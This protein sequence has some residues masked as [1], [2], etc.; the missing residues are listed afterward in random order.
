MARRSSTVEAPAPVPR[1]RGVLSA[2]QTTFN[3]AAAIC[4]LLGAIW[5]GLEIEHIL[6]NDTRFL[7]ESA[8]EPGVAS[9]GFLVEG[10]RYASES[11]I[12]DV[13]R[14]DFGRSIYLCPIRERRLALMGIDWI[15]E[16]SVS[17]IWPNRLYVRIVE[18][19]PVAFVQRAAADGTMAYGLVDTEGVMLDPQR[20]ARLALPVLAGVSATSDARRREQV[21]RFLRLQTELGPLMEGISEVDV[22]DPYNTRVTV[23]YNGRAITL[24]LGDRDFE[25]RYRKF[26]DHRKEV[27]EVV[28]NARVLD[29][30]LKHKFTAVVTEE[31]LPAQ[32]AKPAPKV[33]KEANR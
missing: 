21:R 29:L 26:S 10:V 24:M 28:P 2:L 9:R 4:V 15:K 20:A 19:T 32:D 31:P 33:K 17:R 16:A 6:V 1:G 23:A 30:R 18:R 12:A 3:W 25:P 22:A 27:L 8:P 14:R 7:L 5:A 11:Q 13:F